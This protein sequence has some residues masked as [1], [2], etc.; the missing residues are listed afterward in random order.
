MA[1]FRVAIAIML[2]SVAGLRADPPEKASPKALNPRDYLPTLL[3]KSQLDIA[4]DYAASLDSLFKL[5]Q[6]LADAGFV[7]AAQTRQVERELLQTRI[8][9]LKKEREHLDALDQYQAKS[10]VSSERVR[11]LEEKTFGVLRQQVRKFERMGQDLEAMGKEVNKYDDPDSVQKL[12]GALSRIVSSAEAFRD[13]SFRKDFAMRW[14]YWHRQSDRD[15]AQLLQDKSEERRKILADKID[16]EQD[17]RQLSPAGQKLLAAAEFEIELGR[18]ELTLR[19]YERMP[20]KD[21][22]DAAQRQADMFRHVAA[23]FGAVML[24]GLSQRLDELHANWPQVEPFVY[25]KVD[26]L[27][28]EREPAERAVAGAIKN[29]EAAAT[30][31]ANLRK[32]RTL[33]ETYRIGTR[34]VEMAI[35]QRQQDVDALRS[36][37]VLIENAGNSETNGPVAQ[38]LASEKDLANEKS[39]LVRTWIEIQITRIDLANQLG[40]PAR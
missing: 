14:D 3:L 29:P 27:G 18:F 40:V 33:S 13:T 16:L 19:R 6:T 21:Q 12:R 24:R 8:D 9:V 5:A 2:I 37:A 4:R 32:L 20:W 7:P 10:D 1:M 28:G 23:A 11:E 22:D 26:L 38:V 30:A 35:I 39:R 34:L 17:G 36:P 15:I 31:K 25:E